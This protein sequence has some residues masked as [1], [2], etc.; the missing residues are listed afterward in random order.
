MV[1]AIYFPS[2]ERLIFSAQGTLKE[3]AFL[4]LTDPSWSEMKA[5][6]RDRLA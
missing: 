6:P 3:K 4:A 5:D 1:P 2:G